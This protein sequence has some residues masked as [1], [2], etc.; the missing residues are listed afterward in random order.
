[1]TAVM[2]NDVRGK[3]WEFLH[4]HSAASA[5]NT[6]GSTTHCFSICRLNRSWKANWNQCDFCRVHSPNPCWSHQD[7]YVV[8]ARD[9]KPS[10]SRRQPGN[11]AFGTPPIV[12]CFGSKGLRLSGSKVQLLGERKVRRCQGTLLRTSQGAA[13]LQLLGNHA[14]I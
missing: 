2:K 6:M 1:M 3:D 12:G 9:S 5:V 11:N 8:L 4:I 14:S 7:F 10:A 13:Q